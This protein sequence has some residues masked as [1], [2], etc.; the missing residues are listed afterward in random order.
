M[1]QIIFVLVKELG[2]MG[3]KRSM[4]LKRMNQL[5]RKMIARL[6]I[7]VL[8]LPL[9]RELNRFL[10]LRVAAGTFLMVMFWRGYFIFLELI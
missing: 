10:K 1:L 2:L 3:L 7:Y 5:F 9:T 6:M 4:E 8:T